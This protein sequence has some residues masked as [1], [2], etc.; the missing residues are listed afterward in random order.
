MVENVP[1]NCEAGGGGN[2]GRQNKKYEKRHAPP[3]E[4]QWKVHVVKNGISSLYVSVL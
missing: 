2:G 4:L 3:L 1:L